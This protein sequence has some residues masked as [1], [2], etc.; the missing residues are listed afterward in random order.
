MNTQNEFYEQQK[1]ILFES[2]T[3]LVHC[4]GGD[5]WGL[6]VTKGHYSTRDLADRYGKLE[7]VKNYEYRRE[8]RDDGSVCFS[9]HEECVVFISYKQY[10][11]ELKANENRP[12]V[13]WDYTLIL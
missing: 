10:T 7:C 1:S 11:E 13:L 8:D 2:F 5:G 12:G 3:D 9:N 4:E 6:I